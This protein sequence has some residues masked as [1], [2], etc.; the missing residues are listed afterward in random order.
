MDKMCNVKGF[1]C[2]LLC[3]ALGCASATVDRNPIVTGKI[4]RPA[5]I[6]V[7]D[8]AATPADLPMDSFLAGQNITT[9]T[10][11]TAQQIAEGRKLGNQI[12]TE[13]VTKI[14]AMGMVA[15]HHTEGAHPQINDII[16][17]GYLIS[18]SQG[19]EGERV[20]IGFGTGNTDLKAAVEGFQVTPGGVRKLGEGIADAEGA[21]TP[22]MALGGA[23]FLVT[24]NP[25]GLVVNAGVQAY[26]EGSNKAKVEG[27][28]IQIAQKIADVLQQRFQDQ[29][30]ISPVDR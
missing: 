15:Q 23:M 4:P 5:T 12:A 20:G 6:W 24:H 22:G 26:E 16:L 3:M 29:G 28:A 19:N 11:Q 30:W 2:I 8:F 18:F 13:L 27:R 9:D 14:A 10:P 7:P 21:K 17:R 1:L 25:V